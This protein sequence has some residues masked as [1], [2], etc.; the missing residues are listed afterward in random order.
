MKTY[1][2][3]SNEMVEKYTL[4]KDITNLISITNNIY[5]MVANI[6]FLQIPKQYSWLL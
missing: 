4:I 2:I 3:T 5:I 1:K 6:R